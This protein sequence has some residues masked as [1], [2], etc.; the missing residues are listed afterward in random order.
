MLKFDISVAICTYNRFDYLPL[1]IESLKQQTLSDERFEIIIVDNSDDDDR[2]ARFWQ[3]YRLP[4]NSRLVNT[5][6]PG[7]S[8]AR[9]CALE[10]SQSP[11][12]VYIDD[13]AVATQNLLSSYIEYFNK[14]PEANVVGG[15]INPIWPGEKPDWLPPSLLGCLTIVNHGNS[16]RFFIGRGILL[17]CKYGV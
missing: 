1:A 2:A 14:Y 16:D 7:L 5:T 6:P 13:D 12:I 4:H 17:W 15:K 3:G 8:R 10:L 9:N 11:I